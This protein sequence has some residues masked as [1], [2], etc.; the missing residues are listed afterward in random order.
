M[1]HVAAYVM[2]LGG[3]HEE[4]VQ[5]TIGNTRPGYAGPR[6]SVQGTGM[7]LT[8][9]RLSLKNGM[10]VVPLEPIRTPKTPPHDS[11]LEVSAWVAEHNTWIIETALRACPTHLIETLYFG[12][13]APDSPYDPAGAPGFELLC[14]RH[15]DFAPV[16]LRRLELDPLQDT[17][18]TT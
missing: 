2:C 17:P 1:N 6:L 14:A 16:S 3:D 5:G 15:T 7:L 9:C 11:I 8:G 10:Y 18:T 13:F 12:P 4:G